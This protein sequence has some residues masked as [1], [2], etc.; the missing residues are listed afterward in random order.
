VSRP[1]FVAPLGNSAERIITANRSTS[2]ELGLL[3][4]ADSSA[5]STKASIIQFISPHAGLASYS[6]A[7][8]TS[9]VSNDI[10][11][12]D[13]SGFSELAVLAAAPAQSS[14]RLS[15]YGISSTVESTAS[16][17]QSQQF[18]QQSTLI[19]LPQPLAEIITSDVIYDMKYT[20][21]SLLFVLGEHAASAGSGAVYFWQAY[22]QGQLLFDISISPKDLVCSGPLKLKPAYNSQLIALGLTTSSIFFTYV[23]CEAS[24]LYLLSNSQP[25]SPIVYSILGNNLNPQIF[26]T[27]KAFSLAEIA[28]NPA[29]NIY[30]VVSGASGDCVQISSQLTGQTLGQNCVPGPSTGRILRLASFST[31]KQPLLLVIFQ[32]PNNHVT[33]AAYSLES[34]LLSAQVSSAPSSPTAPTASS[35]GFDWNSA[36]WDTV[37]AFPGVVFNDILVTAAQSS[38]GILNIAERKAETETENSMEISG[39]NLYFLAQIDPLSFSSTLFRLDPLT[40]FINFY[41][42]SQLYA[43]GLI[44]PQ[45]CQF[46]AGNLQ[47]L[48]S[49]HRGSKVLISAG[50]GS[51]QASSR[52]RAMQNTGSDFSTTT[53]QVSTF[54]AST[55]HNMLKLAKSSDFAVPAPQWSDLPGFSASSEPSANPADPFMDSPISSALGSSSS[56]GWGYAVIAVVLAVLLM[57]VLIVAALMFYRAKQR[58]QFS[59][60][61]QHINNAQ[62]N[63]AMNYNVYGYDNG[64]YAGANL[65]GIVTKQ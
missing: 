12:F 21:N 54:S 30:S 26:D 62:Q 55:F 25:G 36:V 23:Q 32:A 17:T 44:Y 31:S 2:N 22:K 65:T 60:D 6:L 63:A 49:S 13:K 34:F 33:L 47:L 38:A 28:E 48:C 5:N 37:L 10:I 8:A 59:Q 29:N 19:A 46:V 56:G 27:D 43:P 7:S 35:V 20:V 58:A 64:S 53:T 15:F 39:E 51:S 3:Y 40:G 16:S 50:D 24:G 11:M 45:N 52:W 18:I 1:E 14:Y 9:R 4:S 61:V 42:H 57:L 41:A